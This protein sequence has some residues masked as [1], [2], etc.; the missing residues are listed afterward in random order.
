M[1]LGFLSSYLA[2][3]LLLLYFNFECMRSLNIFLLLLIFSV[4]QNF[5]QMNGTKGQSSVAIKKPLEVERPKIVIGLVVDQMRWDYLYRYYEKYGENGFKKLIKD[6]YNCQ[7]ASINYAPSYTACGHTCIYT[8]SVPAIHGIT[9]NDWYD[10]NKDT[11]VYCTTDTNYVGRGTNNSS[12][13]MSPNNMKVSTI[14]DEL[15]LATNFKSRVIG[16]ALKDRSSI[17]PAGHSANAAFWYDGKVNNFISSSY[18]MDSLPTWVNEFNAKKLA[19]SYLTQNWNTLYPI[20]KYTESSDDDVPFENPFK[21]ETKATFEHKVSELS[22]VN[23]EILKYTPYGNTFTFDFARA[24][25][26]GAQL[27]KRGITDFL[28][29]S[30]S[31][32]DY[33]GHQFGPNSVEQEDDFLRLDIEIAGFINYLDSTYGKNN[34]LMFLTADHGAAHIPLYLKSKKIPSGSYMYDTLAK[35]V[36]NEMSKWYGKGNWVLAFENMH[37]YL[38]KKSLLDKK[39]DIDEAKNKVK[40]FVLGLPGVA[41]VFDMSNLSNENYPSELIEKIK[42]SYYSSRSGDLFVNFEPAWFEGLDKGTTHGSVFPYDTHIPLIF[43]GWKINAKEDFSD[44]KMTDIAATIASLLHIQQP[45]GCIGR[46]IEGI[47]R[48]YSQF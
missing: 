21:N 20:M 42:N 26:E 44:I 38:N 23:T 12:G 18:Y 45:S 6:G 36:N 35:M 1:Y 28:A 25:I 3:Y 4:Q 10:L 24:T 31:A 37:I 39:I 41:Q 8:G 46:P 15:R 5:A 19:Q 17:L 29:I 2:Y 9:G 11:S 33:I 40:T 14:G 43:Y 7:N 30:L 48:S 34:Y 47:L 16:I 13:S 27:G 22:A 32:T